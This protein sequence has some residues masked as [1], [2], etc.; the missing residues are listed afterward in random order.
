[1]EKES[2]PETTGFD[3]RT[4]GEVLRD[5]RQQKKLSLQDVEN[6]TSIRLTYIQAIE[7]N[8]ID[9]QISPVYAKGFISQYANYLGLDPT[10][11]F[12]QHSH[13]LSEAEKQEFDYGIGT[14]ERRNYVSSGGIKWLPN[15][16]YVGSTVLVLICGWY[17]AKFLG[18]V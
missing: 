17:L 15:L 3:G 8:R 2:T 6:A 1:M 12:S 14:L 10:G 11:L 13:G 16:M 18:V 9:G 7:E 5:A 4:L